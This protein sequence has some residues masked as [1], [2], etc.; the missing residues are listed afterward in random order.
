MK[1]PHPYSKSSDRLS[2]FTD[3][4]QRVGS[5]R[6]AQMAPGIAS[7]HEEIAPFLDFTLQIRSAT[8]LKWLEL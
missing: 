8:H 6:H 2:L 3:Q 5:V 4:G 7:L 1:S